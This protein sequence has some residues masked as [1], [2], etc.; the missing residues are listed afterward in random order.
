MNLYLFTI[1]MDSWIDEITIIL[2]VGTHH[3]ESIS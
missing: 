2:I 1:E 3:N